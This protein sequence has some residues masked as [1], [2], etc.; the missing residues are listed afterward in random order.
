MNYEFLLAIDPSGSYYEGK[1]TTG[2]C[3]YNC[4]DK[5]ITK[6]GDIEAVKFEAMADYWDAHVSLIEKYCAK[7]KDRICVI[8]EDFLL[9]AHKADSQINSHM[10]TSKLIGVLQHHCWV[11]TIPYHMQSASE[12][13]TR[14]T[15]SILN[16][17]GYIVKKGRYF[18]LPSDTKTILNGH[19]RD[20][21]RHA[22]HFANFKN[23]RKFSNGHTKYDR[24]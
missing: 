3:I 17:N 1:G 4:K 24:Q 23:E 12:V 21:I 13:K 11:H 6:A 9:Y 15:D 18:V 14:W 20:A 2:W 16:Y 19:K 10:E 5:C 8:M 22:V 7:Y